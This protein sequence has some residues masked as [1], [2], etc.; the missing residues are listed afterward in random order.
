VQRVE[1]SFNTVL[2]GINL[3]FVFQH[4]R[5]DQDLNML[6]DGLNTK[7]QGFTR[8]ELQDRE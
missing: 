1:L 5:P 3:K 7:R 2:N 6:K 8:S 4:S